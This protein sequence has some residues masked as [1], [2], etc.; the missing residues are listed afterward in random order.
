MKNTLRFSGIVVLILEAI[1]VGWMG[2]N[3]FAFG[4][5]RQHAPLS[6]LLG[7]YVAIGYLVACLFHI[8][9]F[10]TLFLMFQATKKMTTF[11]VITLIIGIIS[12]ITIMGE[13][14]ALNDIGDCLQAGMPC[15]PEWNLLYFAFLPHGL[16]Q[17]LLAILMVTFLRQIPHE[18]R[19]NGTSKDETIFAIV[20]LIGACCGLLGLG[21]T[22]LIFLSPVKVQTL[23][24]I[25]FPYCSF[26][27]LPYGLILLYWLV[28]KRKEKRSDWYDEKQWQDIN[29]AGMVAMIVSIPVM[30]LLFGLTYV[31]PN[32]PGVIMWFPA[33]LFSLLL[34]FSGGTLYYSRK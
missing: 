21:F 30:T 8:V 34:V 4:A 20:H 26:I 24:W 32:N 17:I 18:S 2:Y 15:T 28:A 5:I 7:T 13:L 22:V 19:S 3:V 31:L 16:F 29:K 12:F 23:K 27:L 6:Q 25:I 33:Y 11:R 10:V 14:G 1:S 9:A